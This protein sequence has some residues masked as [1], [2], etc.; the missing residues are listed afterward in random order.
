MLHGA[1]ANPRDFWKGRE[2]QRTHEQRQ[3]IEQHYRYEIGFA[4]GMKAMSPYA[5][6]SRCRDRC[7]AA[8]IA[9]KRLTL[10][11]YW[12]SCLSPLLLPLHSALIAVGCSTDMPSR[13]AGVES[14]PFFCSARFGAS[15]QFLYT[16]IHR[17]NT[18]EHEL[19]CLSVLCACCA[20]CC[21][22]GQ[23]ET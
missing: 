2:L 8:T 21:V 3:Q 7:T 20:S 12:L 11:F 23:I 1:L 15:A 9:A 17:H 6:G 13:N 19:V 18:F 14:C 5:N 10:S 16:H 4:A 22:L